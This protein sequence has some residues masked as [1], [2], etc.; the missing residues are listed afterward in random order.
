MVIRFFSRT[1]VSC[2][3]SFA[4][5]LVA[6]TVAHAQVGHAPESSPF[7]DQKIGQTVSLLAGRLSP[8]RDPGNVAPKGST[9]FGLRYDVSIGGPSSLFVR[10]LMSPSE[11][12][13]V[14]PAE[15]QETRLLG[16]PSTVTH[17]ADMGLD[18]ALTGPKTWRSL[19]PSLFGA[20]GMAT[21][22][23]GIDQGGYRFGGKFAIS[24][25]A[26]VRIIPSGRISYRID[27]SN[28]YWQYQYPDAF[29]VPASD[30]SAV[31]ENTRSRNAWRSNW[32]LTAGVSWRLFQ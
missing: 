24:Y 20:I 27:A 18:I 21:D 1:V 8:A 2:V 15:P 4:S 12:R 31:L 3:T 5:V 9:A 16:T 30:G 26:S 19:M 13:V 28:F 14:L 10:Y 7:R 25:G 23:R 32:S 29:F 22:F 6:T 11:R 17:I